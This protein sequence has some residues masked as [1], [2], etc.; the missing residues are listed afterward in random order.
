MLLQWRLWRWSWWMEVLLAV[1]TQ[2][3]TDNEHG[4]YAIFMNFLSWFVLVDV[5]CACIAYGNGA[6][7]R[8][9]RRKMA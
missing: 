9:C 7:V 5:D 8:I 4:A 6:G 1:R 2:K 3:C